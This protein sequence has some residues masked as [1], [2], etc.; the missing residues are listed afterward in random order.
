M[1]RH[2]WF[3]LAAM[4]I[5]IGVAIYF[6][7]SAQAG[8]TTSLK[9]FE[10]IQSGNLTVFPVV[11]STEHDTS[12]FLTLD[13]GL[14]SGDVVVTEA[15]S[16]R[17]LQRDGSRRPATGDQVNTLVLINR[18]SKPLILL[19][20]E[21]V[22]GGKQDRIIA[23]D[24]IVPAHSDPLDVSVF[25]VEPGRWTHKT[26]NFSSG[27]SNSNAVAGMAAPKVRAGAMA[28]KN[29]QEVWSQVRENNKKVAD[30]ASIPATSTEVT[31][32]AQSPLVETTSSQAT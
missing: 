1:K 16:V 18:S 2:L 25:C 28:S 32:T 13:E 20:G 19:A 14:T 5:T 4:A 24:R 29:Q 8:P 26:A 11:M 23:K 7:P 6:A 17:G 21:V 22:T 12:G 27:S 31:V 3:L 10:P 30:A 15:G 9:V